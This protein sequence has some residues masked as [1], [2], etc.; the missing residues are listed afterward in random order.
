MWYIIYIHV[1]IYIVYTYY[2]VSQ[3]LCFVI[4]Q[5]V[6]LNEN[7]IKRDNFLKLFHLIYL[8]LV[9]INSPSAIIYIFTLSVYKIFFVQFKSFLLF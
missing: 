9:E 1:H 8:I 5:A 6:F 7:L 4:L 3:I 2:I